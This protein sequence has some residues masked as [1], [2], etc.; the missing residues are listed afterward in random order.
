MKLNRRSG[1]LVVAL[2]SIGMGMGTALTVLAQ[3]ASSS[4]SSSAPAHHH[5]GHFRGRRF[6]PGSMLLG[7]TLRAA[8]QLNLTADQKAQIKTILQTA[9][10]QARANAQA[11]SIDIAVL[12]NPADP[13]YATELETLKSNAANRIQEESE[14]QSQIYNVLTAQQKEQLPTVLA[15]IKAKQ[16]A[17]RAAW[18]AQHSSS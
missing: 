6:G 3:D 13:N 15:S 2:A 1:M 7:M 5:H 18:A 14:L 11:G 17:R 8:H 9:R 12:G 4:S 16:A 10:S